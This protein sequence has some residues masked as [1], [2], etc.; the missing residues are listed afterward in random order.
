LGA[1]VYFVSF[2]QPI[3][4]CTWIATYGVPNDAGSVADFVT[5]EGRDFSS[6]PNDLEIRERDLTGAQVDGAGFHI[7]V[8]CP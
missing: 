7:E 1:G 2:A 3:A 6:F 5:V 4:N 8:L